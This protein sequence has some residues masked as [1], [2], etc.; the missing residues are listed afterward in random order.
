MTCAPMARRAFLSLTAVAACGRSGRDG[1]TDQRSS[2]STAPEIA[3]ASAPSS[4][5][6]PTEPVTGRPR[7]RAGAELLRD[8]FPG[9]EGL[10]R[11]ALADG[12]TPLEQVTALGRA[13]GVGE[14]WVKRDD[15]SSAL[16]GGNKVRKLERLLADATRRGA[17]RVVTFGGA[18]SNH[19]VATAA[20]GRRL[21]L[22]VKVML[23]PQPKSVDVARHIAAC[24]ELGA[25]V[26]SS[27][28]VNDAFDRARREYERYPARA[29]FVIAPG[30]TSPLGDVGLIDAAF[31]LAA[32]IGRVGAPRFDVV[33]VAMGTM[34]SAA[35][36]SFGLA[37]A[38]LSPHLLAVRCS[39]SA[40][41][42]EVG[43]AKMK[44][45]LRAYLAGI[46]GG[47][48]AVTPLSVELDGAMLGAGYGR[49]TA[50]AE[51]AVSMARD[52]A[53]L[54]LETTY[55]GKALAGV[56]ARRGELTR[57]NVLFW[58]SQPPPIRAD[59]EAVDLA[60]LPV[61]LRRY[62]ERPFG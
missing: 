1:E 51:R 23:A 47:L 16:F 61:E 52:L 55:T 58:A 54:E 50:A 9:T 49:P 42:S 20:F 60:R 62:F 59:I 6:G 18:G 26:E 2:P 22:G 56:M 5:V 28:G 45:E 48:G 33:V 21:G 7:I 29:P 11:V 46:D 40:T 24:L 19:A 41:S 53:G 15:L 44:R 30:G 25:E 8:A 27:D 32:D 38:G 43:F 17:K 13:L 37:A 57:A 31:E 3:T 10:P 39:S 4:A 14:L 36:L 35:G 34:G 12:P